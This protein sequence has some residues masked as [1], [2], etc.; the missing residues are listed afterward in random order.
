M[1]PHGELKK[2]DLKNWPY[3][4]DGE[5]DMHRPYIDQI[6]LKCQK[7]GGKMA[8]VPDL[9]DVWFDSGAMPYAQWASQCRN[10]PFVEFCPSCKRDRVPAS[11]RMA[12]SAL[13]RQF[14]ADFI[15]EAIDQTRGWFFTLLAISTLLKKGAPYKN[16]MVLGHTLDEKGAKMSKSKGNFVPVMELMDKYGVDVLR[17]YFLSSMT[18]GESKSV[19]PREIEDKQKGFFGTFGNCLKFYELYTNDQQPT[20][21][22]KKENLLD[23][24]ILSR[25]NGLI[26][27]AT[28]GLDKYEITQVAKAVE[29]FVVEDLSNWWLRRSRKRKEA[30]GLLRF[31]LLEIAKII[32]PFIPFSAEDVH[33]RLTNDQRPTTNNKQSVHLHDWPKVNKK[34]IDKELEK[35]MEEIQNIVSLGLAQRKEKQI[36]VRQ[37]LRAV[38]LGLLNEFPKDLEVLMKGELNIKEIVYDKSQKE[39]V[40]L[41]TELDEALIQEGISLEFTRKIQDM[42]KEAKFNVGDKAFASWNTDS[43]VVKN[44]INK[45][46]DSIESITSTNIFAG[47]QVQGEVKIS[48][49]SEIIPGVKISIS[50]KK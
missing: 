38:C 45:Y 34:L 40:V 50:I 36:K 30:L 23:K 10:C 3:D 29:K 27:E 37:P 5:L 2:V 44:A 17:W 7:C 26:E 18:I 41:N 43:D 4:E 6:A 11:Q 46:Q 47:L 49:E 20:T 1:P 42:R 12:I 48:Q 15:V 28:E 39:L 8:K 9:I 16:V 21:N 33:M 19:I 22:D 32:A 24:W 25:L 31:L 35:Q 13:G 14:P